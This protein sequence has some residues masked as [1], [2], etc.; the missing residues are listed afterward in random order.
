MEPFAALGFSIT[1]LEFNTGF[2]TQHYFFYG[3]QTALCLNRGSQPSF[4]RRQ[5]TACEFDLREFWEACP[6]NVKRLRPSFDFPTTNASWEAHYYSQAK[7]CPFQKLES[8]MSRPC[9]NW[10]CLTLCQAVKG[11]SAASS[12]NSEANQ[13]LHY[14]Q[15]IE[16]SVFALG[17]PNS[18][19]CHSKF[20]CS[21]AL[22][23][24]SII[25]RELF[26]TSFC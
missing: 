5:H 22:V 8:I 7:Q 9:H 11:L 21:V 3:I 20:S 15:G 24:K 16:Q 18:T 10:Q 4:L 19:P 23:S 17:N 2:S 1:V 12:P 25:G 6:T 26:V 13:T 14:P